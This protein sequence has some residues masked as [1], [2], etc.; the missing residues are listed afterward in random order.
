MVRSLSRFGIYS[1]VFVFGYLFSLGQDVKHYSPPADSFQSYLMNIA[2]T[3]WESE[4]VYHLAV[5]FTLP[6]KIGYLSVSYP[7]HRIAIYG[8]RR[9]RVERVELPKDTFPSIAGEWKGGDSVR[10]EFD[11]PKEYADQSKGWDLRFC[12]GDGSGCLRSS[13]LLGDGSSPQNL[14]GPNIRVENR[15]GVDFANVVVNGK[16]FGDIKAGS[17]SDYKRME[18]AYRYGQVFL[19]TKLGPLVFQ[20]IDFVGEPQ[21]GVGNYTYVLTIEGG[22]IRIECVTD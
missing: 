19:S 1:C 20:P 22:Q 7:L 14:H 8:S 12:I 9:Q 13:N 18:L 17:H 2:V 4:T 15:S 16:P 5:Q 10:F 3:R 11:L 21:L 6:E